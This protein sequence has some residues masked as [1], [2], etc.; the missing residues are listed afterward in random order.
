MRLG[1]GKSVEVVGRYFCTI[2]CSNFLMAYMFKKCFLLGG[3][4]KHY[5]FRLTVKEYAVNMSI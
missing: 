5:V 1:P 4:F 2:L 3:S